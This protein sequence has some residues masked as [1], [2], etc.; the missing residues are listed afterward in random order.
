[1]PDNPQIERGPEAPGQASPDQ[2]AESLTLLAEGSFDV[3]VIGGGITGAGVARDAAMRGLSVALV[4]A[5]DFASGTSS[6][7]SRLV[8]GGVRYLEHGQLGLV[9]EASRER[10]ILATIAPH[11]VRPL[12]FM[13]PVYEKARIRLWKLRAGLFLY[14]TLALGRNL[15]RHRTLTTQKITA[16]E[17]ELRHMGMVGGASYYDASTDDIRLTL[18]TVLSARD[19][20]AIVLNHVSVHDLL[21][22][23]DGVCGAR[24]IDMRSGVEL[25]IRARTVVN[26]AG[27]W[28]DAIVR[29]A[30]PQARRAVRGTKGV[31]VSVPRDR[32][33]NNGALT[34]LSPIDGR[35]MFVLPAGAFSIIGTTD[36]EYDGRPERVRA[37]TADVT[38]LLRS[39]NAFF[40]GAHLMPADVV[41]AWAGIRPLVA[42]GDKDPDAASRE[43]AVAWT[44][45]GLLSVTGGKLTTYRAMAA[46]VMDTIARRLRVGH[47]SAATHKLRLPGGDIDSLEDELALARATLGAPDIAEHLV[48]AY[49]TRWRSIWQMASV[50]RSLAARLIPGLPYIAAELDWGISQEMALTLGDL[51]IRRLHVAFETRDHGLAIAPA[52]AELFAPLMKWNVEDELQSFRREIDHLFGIAEA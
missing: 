50:D 3:L 14:D 51:L 44:V 21:M 34:L 49:G 6:R 47:R 5:S 8:H 24:A 31:H 28:S 29:M 15:G 10:R 22:T 18:A 35:V 39:A 2:R 52:V 45:P 11:L 23:S 40:P 26:A 43:H 41:A 38:Y 30:E 17:P 33:R 27:P 13:W 48:H 37:T 1:M 7:S 12:Q 20:G 19:A 42:S 4:E 36:T 46:D 32:I 9:F 16:L 25:E